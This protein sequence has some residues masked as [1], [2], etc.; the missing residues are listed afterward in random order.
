MITVK[1][2]CGETYHADEQHVGRRIRCGKCG[3]LLEIVAVPRG[4]DVVGS[5]A[6][7]DSSPQGPSVRPGEVRPRSPSRP[8]WRGWPVV[9]GVFGIVLIFW[10]AYRMNQPRGQPS[11][12]PPR[13]EAVSEPS[14]PPPSVTGP[15][16]SPPPVAKLGIRPLSGTELC[17]RHGSGLGRVRIDNGTGYDAV[18]LLVDCATDS[19]RR[20]IFIRAGEAASINSVSPRRYH[21]RFQ[22]GSDWLAE[23]RFNRVL[24]TS[25]FDE[26]LDFK[27]TEQ[28]GATN[29]HTFEVS[30]QPVPQGNALT[31]EIPDERFELPPP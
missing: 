1:C 23:R 8:T 5:K 27:E 20:A 22:L 31:H 15:S 10:V 24:G 26:V 21:L 30:L 3:T 14:V 18:A 17:R 2:A 11:G 6:Q 7:A 9:A 16:A 12:T 4:R 19:A 13:P 28:D 29:Y 25:E